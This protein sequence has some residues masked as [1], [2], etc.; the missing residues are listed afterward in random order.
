MMRFRYYAE[1]GR[2]TKEFFKAEVSATEWAFERKREAFEKVAKDE[3]GSLSIV[4]VITLKSTDFLRRIIARVGGQGGVTLSAGKKHSCWWCAICGD[5]FEWRAPNR[6]LGVQPVPD[7]QRFLKGMRHRKVCVKTLSV[8]SSCWRT[9][10][11]MVIAQSRV[12]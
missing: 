12:L 6:L 5:N 2:K 7:R 11:K 10:K 3:V 1:I 9:I 8:R 4:K